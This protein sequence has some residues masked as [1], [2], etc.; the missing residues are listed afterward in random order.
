MKVFCFD[1]DDT[2]YKE[3]D[4][5][6]SAYLE[7]VSYAFTHSYE[8]K[9]VFQVAYEGMLE[10]YLSGG[11]AFQYLNTYM[12]LNVPISEYL[13][14]YRAHRPNINMSSETQ[15]VLAEIKANGDVVG[16]ITDGR[17]VQQTNKIEALQL[18]RYISAED[19]VISEAFG[20][21]KPDERNY[22]FF[23]RRYPNA[24]EFYYIGDNIDKDFYAPNKLGW[25]TIVLLDNGDNIHKLHSMKDDAYMPQYYVKQIQDIINYI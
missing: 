16:I 1:L 10:A 19:I 17:I 25:K 24:A 14:I 15:E 18:Y 22:E 12:G 3:I 8:G 20:S 23:V 9:K 7:V 2:L 6:K 4:F 11:N 21:E 13:E 5:L